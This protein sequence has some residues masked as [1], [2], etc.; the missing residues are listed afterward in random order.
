MSECKMNINDMKRFKEILLEAEN[1]ISK[2]NCDECDYNIDCCFM[3]L[4]EIIS[5]CEMFFVDVL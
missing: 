5:E 1:I 4:E 2:F 3:E